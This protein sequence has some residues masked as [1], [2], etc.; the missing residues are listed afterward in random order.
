MNE[1]DVLFP[2]LS[3]TDQCVLTTK[4]TDT[5]LEHPLVI[6]SDSPGRE[7]ALIPHPGVMCARHPS[8]QLFVEKQHIFPHPQDLA[9]SPAPSI[10]RSPPPS[11]EGQQCGLFGQTFKAKEE[12]VKLSF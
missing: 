1:E 8:L 4:I 12:A 2:M 11:P 6:D 9:L 3:A 10:S 7:V 5:Y